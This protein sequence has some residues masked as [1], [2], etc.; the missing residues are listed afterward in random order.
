V[1]DDIELAALVD[2]IDWTPFFL[3]WE[4]GGRYP[5]ILDDPEKGA[6]ARSLFEDAHAML[7]R[8]VAERWLTPHAVCGLFPANR[9]GDDVIVWRGEQRDEPLARFHFLRQQTQRRTGQPNLCLAD[10]VGPVG[11]PDYLG[12]FAVTSGAEVAERAAAFEAEHDDYHAI[13]LK[14]LADRLAEALAEHL[15]A[16]VRREFWGYAADEALGNDDLIQERY[17]GIRPAPGYP[18]CPEHTEKGELWRLLDAEKNAGISLTESFAMDPAS[19]VSGF[20]FAHPDAR[21]FTV[22]K[23]ARDQVEDYA[24]RKGFDL[25]TAERWLAPNLGYTPD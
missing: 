23:I 17:R 11:T 2:C 19:S 6:I 5:A 12:A 9:D 24:R 3:T 7:E 14:A 18:A 15:H 20:Y 4:L 8:I 10:F 1:V 13:L 25:A 21:Y 22:G 16:R